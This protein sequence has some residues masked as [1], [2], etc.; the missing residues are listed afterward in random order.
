MVREL[1]L[2][3]RETVRSLS[4]VGVGKLKGAAPSTR[5]P[6]WTN[7]WCSGCHANGIAR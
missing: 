5:G 6:E 7:L 2:E 1:G 4:A 3:R